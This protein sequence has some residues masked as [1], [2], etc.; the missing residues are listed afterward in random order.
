MYQKILLAVDGSD[1]SKRAAEEAI[2][3]AAL[4]G[5]RVHALYVVSKWGVAP[6]AGNDVPPIFL[7]S[8][9]EPAS[10]KKSRHVWENGDGSRHANRLSRLCRDV[11]DRGRGGYATG[12]PRTV[13]QV[14]RGLSPGDRG[15]S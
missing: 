1:A 7:K 3:I 2:Q 6:Y 5:A 14:Y 12:A 8:R 11:A 13:L 9:K 10:P 15:Y 4:A